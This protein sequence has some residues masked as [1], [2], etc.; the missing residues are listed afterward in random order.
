MSKKIIGLF[1]VLVALV[2]MTFTSCSSLDDDYEEETSEIK[3]ITLTL[4]GV[5]GENTTDEA[6][7]AVE[8]KI[9]EYTVKNY[10]TTI[11]LNLFYQD[12][13]EDAISDVYEKLEQQAERDEIAEKAAS[14]A[15]KVAKQLEKQLSTDDQKEKKRAQR[16]Y[17]KWASANAVENEEGIEMKDDVVLDI[18]LIQG[19]DNYLTAVDEE[20]LADLS[21]YANGTYKMIYKYVNPIIIQSAKRTGMLYGVPTNKMLVADSQKPYYYAIRTDLLEK[22]GIEIAEGEIPDIDGKFK[23]FFAQVK[24]NERCEVMLAPPAAIQNYDFYCDDMEQF[25]AYGAYNPEDQ[26]NKSAAIDFTFE[27]LKVAAFPDDYAGKAMFYFNKVSGY[28]NS[29][30]FAPVGSTVENTDFAMG[31]F[32]GT[33]DEVKAQL[34]DKADDYTY[35][36]YRCARVTSDVVFENMLAVSEGC[37]YPDRAFQVITGLNTVPAL[38]NLIT[39]GIE[40]VHYVVNEDGKTVSRLNNDWD[41]D[42][43]LYGNSLIGYVPEELGA[44]YQKKAIEHNSLVKVSSFLG[45]SNGLEEPDD[46]EAFEKINEVAKRYIHEF[47]NGA[48]D[49]NALL[50]EAREA[51]GGKENVLGLYLNAEE[52]DAYTPSYQKLFVSLH[53]DFSIFASNR[54]LDKQVPNNDFL[55]KAEKERLDAI[56]RAEREQALKDAQNAENVDDEAVEETETV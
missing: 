30:Y 50:Q 5:K 48:N 54:P 19:F 24:E 41:I 36:L 22:Y 14:A 35:C 21:S 18:F 33:L 9:N 17:E 11:D 45:Y 32:Y 6:V 52:E 26:Q 53:S 37:K 47:M 15:A 8:A 28:R 44:D 25:P 56:A 42:F 20:K 43:E 16:A 38:R 27:I 4:Y 49:T 29:G 13:Y 12:E 39:F 34:G 1:L 31:V 10:K 51:M 46:I 2:T 3:D 40:N 55:S 23:D 7:E